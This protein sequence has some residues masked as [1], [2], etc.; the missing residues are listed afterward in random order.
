[1]ERLYSRQIARLILSFFF[2]L[3]RWPVKK[4]GD[5]VNL[6][7]LI[8]FC[9]KD[10]K[11]LLSEFIGK[12]KTALQ[13]LRYNF[14]M[15]LVTLQIYGMINANDFLQLLLELDDKNSVITV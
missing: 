6:S 7:N 4:I 10:Y 1:M 2:E 12:N 3:I 15:H 9:K 14:V 8:A 5:N 13:K 11:N